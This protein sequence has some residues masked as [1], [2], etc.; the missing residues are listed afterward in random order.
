MTD[1]QTS[2]RIIALYPHLLGAGHN[3]KDRDFWAEVKRLGCK[4]STAA[5]TVD[6]V[7]PSEHLKSFC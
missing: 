2:D 6:G 5:S 1:R 3:N 4:R 7:I